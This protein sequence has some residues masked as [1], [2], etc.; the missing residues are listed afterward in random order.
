MEQAEVKIK[1]SKKDI[2]RS[3][4]ILVNN[5]VTDIKNNGQNLA[6][7]IERL[8]AKMNSNPQKMILIHLS[9]K[10]QVNLMSLF[11]D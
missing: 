9:M 2:I 4:N 1:N 3:V 8:K 6:S 5:A 11:K 7:K 10:L